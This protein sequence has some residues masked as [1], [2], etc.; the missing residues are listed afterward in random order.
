MALEEPVGSKREFLAL[1]VKITIKL[2]RF[3]YVCIARCELQRSGEG[4]NPVIEELDHNYLNDIKGLE[5]PTSEN[6]AKWLWK[7]LKANLPI[8]TKIVVQESPYSGAIYQGEN[9]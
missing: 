8:L 5:N 2:I 3:F 4:V 1:V 7:R 9:D 6:I